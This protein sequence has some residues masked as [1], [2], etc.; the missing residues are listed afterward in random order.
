MSSLKTVIAWTSLWLAVPL[1]A[2]WTFIE[3]LRP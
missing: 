1:L 2:I 3:G